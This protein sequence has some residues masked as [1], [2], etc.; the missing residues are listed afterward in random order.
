MRSQPLRN[1]LPGNSRYVYQ[2]ED[3]Q[4]YCT[5]ASFTGGLRSRLAG[6]VS[7]SITWRTTYHL[8]FQDQDAI[9]AFLTEDD[10]ALEQIRW[11]VTLVRTHQGY[12]V[13]T[14]GELKAT[15]SRGTSLTEGSGGTWIE[16]LLSS[17]AKP[18][19]ESSVQYKPPSF[20]QPTVR[21]SMNGIVNEEHF[22][23]C[24]TRLL[25]YHQA[26]EAIS[27]GRPQTL[28]EGRRVIVEVGKDLTEFGVDNFA[29]GLALVVP[30]QSN[31]PPLMAELRAGWSEQS[32][33][34][35]WFPKQSATLYMLDVPPMPHQSWVQ[36]DPVAH[37]RL[38]PL[39]V[40]MAASHQAS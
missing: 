29:N 15:V 26:V 40:L 35:G 8:I 27:L 30:D 23:W 34:T 32:G 20:W 7:D 1:L 22:T 16:K 9:D 11:F 19:E 36:R 4:W 3:G 38:P 10:P 28:L 39:D 6:D 2:Q 21:W 37:H 24:F 12:M 18:H 25:Q 31:I 33:A 14:S 17:Q 5:G 13:M